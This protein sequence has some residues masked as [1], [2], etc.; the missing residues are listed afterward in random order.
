LDLRVMKS[1][2]ILEHR[3]KLQFGAESFNLTNH[4]NVLR[5]SPYFAAGTDRLGTYGDIVESLPGRQ[6]QLVFHLEY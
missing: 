4:T 1:I 6:V 3:E 2:H 5:V